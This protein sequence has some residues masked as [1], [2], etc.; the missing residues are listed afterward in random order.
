MIL[1]E[2][3]EAKFRRDMFKEGR[4]VGHME[5]REEGTMST[6]QRLSEKLNIPE[7]ELLAMLS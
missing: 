1:S 2:F 3:D 6:V 5:G 7:A 4:E